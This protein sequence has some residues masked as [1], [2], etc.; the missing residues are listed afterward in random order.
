MRDL[1][2]MENVLGNTKP[3]LAKPFAGNNA[4]PPPVEALDDTAWDVNDLWPTS[5][6]QV[7]IASSDD[8]PIIVSE[9]R[10]Q[11][12]R[13][14]RAKKTEHP[15]PPVPSG[16]CSSQTLHAL[17]LVPTQVPGTPVNL[18]PSAERSTTGLLGMGSN[19]SSPR[20]TTERKRD[21]V[22]FSKAIHK[23]NGFG[24]NGAITTCGRHQHLT[25]HG[26]IHEEA[27]MFEIREAMP[28]AVPLL[29]KK[30][31]RGRKD[32]LMA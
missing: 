10:L 22:L 17:P 7:S 32:P 14:E 8:A 28:D 13:A 18:P 26:E 2:R 23:V 16:P 24:L 31:F 9:S 25:A 21:L 19:L 11:A 12:I 5:E 4:T 30:C 29:C 27:E 15:T 3:T 6:D 20:T 1:E